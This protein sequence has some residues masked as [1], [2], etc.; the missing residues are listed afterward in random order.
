MRGDFETAAAIQKELESLK[1]LIFSEPIVEAVA[2]IKIILEHEGLINTATVRRPQLGV[3]RIRE[4]TAARQLSGSQR[5]R[6]SIVG[7]FLPRQEKRDGSLETSN[8]FNWQEIAQLYSSLPRPGITNANKA[9]VTASNI[10]AL[11]ASDQ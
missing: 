2:R 3:R 4:K 8:E 5:K 11:M 1:E 7:K 10:M 9:T 6:L